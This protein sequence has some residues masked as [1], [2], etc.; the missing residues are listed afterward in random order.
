M[1]VA[2]IYCRI[3]QDREGAGLGVDRQE[4]DARALADRLGLTVA[5]VI[6]DNDLSAFNRRKARPGYAELLAGLKTGHW[7]VLITWHTD[8]L[9]RNVAELEELITIVDAGGTQ[10]HTVKA[11][12]IDLSTPSGRLIARQLGSI[13]VYESEHKSERVQRKMLELAED[14]KPHGGPRPFGYEPGG[15][16]VNPVEADVVRRATRDILG[17]VAVHAVAAQLNATGI[18]TS[19]GKQWTPGSVRAMVLKPRNAG[20][21]VHQGKVI[22]EARW[23]AIVS[24]DEWRAVCA[25]LS[26]PG[27]RVM[28]STTRTRLLSGVALCGAPDCRLPVKGCQSNGRHAYRCSA[29]RPGI[30]IIGHVFRAAG[31]AVDYANPAREIAGLDDYVTRIVLGRLARPD[32]G[33]LVHTDDS[34][35][36]AAA[37]E[38]LILHGRLDEAA[39]HFADGVIDGRQLRTI[40]DSL[41][42]RIEGLERRSVSSR[43]GQILAD[44]VGHGDAIGGVWQGLDVS[45]R[46]SVVDALVTVVLLPT[47]RTG[48]GFRPDS[49]EITWRE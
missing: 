30:P 16:V 8:R 26:A 11:G 36:K 21:R 23:T 22:G 32:A 25:A 9:T 19:A 38:A 27:R 31:L 20:L 37:D 17:G 12:Q 10:V 46:R 34:A 47:G 42:P 44:L 49:V 40:A 13:A 2:V 43:R 35:E 33:D 15:M 1:P 7:D 6:T 14:G 41:R 18:T 4:A 5:S 28:L 45:R 39:Q 24:E 29:V 3:S 48:R